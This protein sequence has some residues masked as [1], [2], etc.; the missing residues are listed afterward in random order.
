MNDVRMRGFKA[1]T[2][3]SRFQAVVRERT[4]RLEAETVA[5]EQAG[6]R[7]LADAVL[8]AV[9]VPAFPRSAMDGYALLAE[10]TYG[11]DTYN[12]LAFN[13]IG[14]VTP[15]RRFE[16]RVGPGQT[17]RIMTGAPLPDGADAVLMAEYTAEHDG[18]MTATA[19]VTPAKHV[20]RIGEDIRAGA[21][22]LPAGRRLRPQDLGVLASIGQ[23][24]VK[25][26]RRPAVSLL[27]TGNELLKPGEAP[28]G[29]MIVDSNSLM[30]RELAIRDGGRVA[31]VRHLRDERLLLREALLHA[32][33][34]LVAI[35]GGSSVGVE[36][37]A[38][39]L[40]A[41]EGELLVHGVAMRPSAPT[42]FG[43]VRGRPVFLLPGNP[44]SCLAAYEFF[45]GLALRRMA[46]L[47][48]SWPYR[49]ARVPLR[50]R[51]ASQ[52]GRVDYARV[53][54]VEGQASLISTS[55]ASI[56]SS[57]T[58]ADGFVVVDQDSEGMPAG[59]TV[60]VWLYD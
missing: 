32:P 57:T 13:V 44:V 56:L 33:G 4:R 16:G 31:E 28:R 51:I 23:A 54:L 2:E 50:E 43:W 25:V 18:V 26:V 21:P 35:T 45:V 11:A 30:L 58:A 42:G 53:R 52:I 46:G 29:A 12:P 20:G 10:E 48:E 27:I 8:S 60:D 38:P 1:R 47:A 40:V 9:D 59:Q 6:G 17:V 39:T 19:S 15:G 5:L 3:V 24:T 41:E 36:D 22:V 55:G 37:H 34:D 7:V 14:E 49:L